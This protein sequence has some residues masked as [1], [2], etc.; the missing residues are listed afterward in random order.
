MKWVLFTPI[1]VSSLKC[2]FDFFKLYSLSYIPNLLSSE[3]WLFI[4]SKFNF[5]FVRATRDLQHKKLKRNFKITN[6]LKSKTYVLLSLNIAFYLLCMNYFLFQSS[7]SYLLLYQSF[8]LLLDYPWKVHS[9]WLLLTSLAC[10]QKILYIRW[11]CI[12]DQGKDGL[13]DMSSRID[14][15]INFQQ[16]RGKNQGK[17]TNYKV[18]NYIS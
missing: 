18:G 5:N 10:F 4:Y 17:L 9:V 8:I 16:M 15:K 12:N 1:S 2:I 3:V 6:L 14:S 11:W 7:M 13:L